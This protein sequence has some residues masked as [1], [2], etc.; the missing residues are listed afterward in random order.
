MIQQSKM[1]KIEFADILVKTQWIDK[2]FP[3]TYSEMVN[4]SN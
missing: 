2:I 4:A 1:T 3:E